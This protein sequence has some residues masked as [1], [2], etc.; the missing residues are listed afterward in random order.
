[1][2]RPVELPSDA[3]LMLTNYMTREDN[4]GDLKLRPWESRV[5]KIM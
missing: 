4:G 2:A 5:Y 1:M 3:R